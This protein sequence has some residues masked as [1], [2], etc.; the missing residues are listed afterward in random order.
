MIERMPVA[1]QSRCVVPSKKE[2][3]RGREREEEKGRKRRRER[4]RDEEI[5]KKRRR[6][7]E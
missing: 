1:R 6:G 4:E 3:K 2:W 7:R 5:G